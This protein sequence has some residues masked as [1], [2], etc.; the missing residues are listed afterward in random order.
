MSRLAPIAAVSILLGLLA[1]PAS[2]ETDAPRRLSLQAVGGLNTVLP[3]YE[4]QVGYRLPVLEDRLEPFL[5]YAPWS[6]SL[7]TATFSIAQVGCRAY[8]GSPAASLQPYG[9]VSLGVADNS[10][11]GLAPAFM[12]GAGM[13]WMFLPTVGLSSSVTLGFP[14]LVRPMVG[15]RIAF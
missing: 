8:F 15:L 10:Y 12:A 13:D 14:T 3:T 2:A 7:S 11:S 1:T 6:A 5:S 4:F 9:V